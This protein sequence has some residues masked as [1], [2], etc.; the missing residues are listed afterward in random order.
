MAD[1]KRSQS[2]RVEAAQRPEEA[3]AL[4]R[5]R[6]KADRPSTAKA[7]QIVAFLSETIQSESEITGLYRIQADFDSAL[8]DQKVAGSNPVTSTKNRSELS[9][10]VRFFSTLCTKIPDFTGQWTFRIHP[11]SNRFC[12]INVHYVRL[13]EKNQSLSV[14][15]RHDQMVQQSM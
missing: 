2:C 8:R 1:A 4:L 7:T 15:F 13:I 5:N 10:S 6:T 14:I 12:R 9:D 3:A 11:D